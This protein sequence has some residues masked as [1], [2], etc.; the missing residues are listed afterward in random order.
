MKL[1]IIIPVYN[2]AGC[3][4]ETTAQLRSTLN[5]LRKTYDVEVIIVDDGSRDNTAHLLEQAHLPDTRVIAHP[6]NQG[7]GA[8]LRTG[9]EHSTG[10]I[11]VTTDFD[12][13]Y[14]FSAIPQLIA[15]MIVTQAD[16][17]VASPY[18]RNGSTRES[19]GH[20]IVLEAGISLMY[21]TLVNRRI[22]TW[23]SLFC[24][25][26]RHV[27]ERLTIREGGAIAS[28][29]LLVGA[30]R[31]RFKVVEIPVSLRQRPAGRSRTR[32]V[33]LIFSH[34]TYMVQLPVLRR[35]R[36]PQTRIKLAA[37]V[38]VNITPPTINEN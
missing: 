8:A 18:H 30:T 14:P 11:I 31:A 27:L 6:N 1:S 38:G 16:I 2:E 12:G 10:D 36:R 13:T 34:F 24:A 4:P 5:Y 33:R 19:T 15:R 37:P 21:R 3:V 32:A 25:Y 29:E 20:H 26:R 7:V 9:F 17:A 28:T 22:H 23:T 35:S